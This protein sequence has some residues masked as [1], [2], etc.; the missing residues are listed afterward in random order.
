MF[1]GKGL[2]V[3]CSTHHDAHSRILPDEGYSGDIIHK[4]ASPEVYA[5]SLGLKFC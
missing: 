5:V 3:Y 2:E 4:L 1:N